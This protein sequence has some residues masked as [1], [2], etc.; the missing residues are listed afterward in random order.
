MLFE[1]KT[2]KKIDGI[3]DLA[4]NNALSSRVGQTLEESQ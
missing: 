1:K 3:N 4:R 2:N